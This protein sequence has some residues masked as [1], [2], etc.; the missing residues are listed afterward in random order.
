MPMMV[1]FIY[2]YKTLKRRFIELAYFP[3]FVSFLNANL[4]ELWETCGSLF[5]PGLCSL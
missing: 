2:T 5:T 1:V 4:I 3:A